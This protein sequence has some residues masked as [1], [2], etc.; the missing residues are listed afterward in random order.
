MI[1]HYFRQIMLELG[2]DLNDDSLK[3]TPKRVA[4]MYKEELFSG[5]S[6]P[7]PTLTTF[8]NK[9]HYSQMLIEQGISVNSVCE[10]HFLPIVGKAAVAYIP[11]K[12]I[13]GLSKLNRIVHHYCR[14]PQ[15]QERLTEQIKNQ[16][17]ETL[18]TENVAVLLDAAHFCVKMRGVKDHNCITR[19]T[20]L[21]G[22]F[23]EQQSTR[24]EFLQAVGKTKELF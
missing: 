5:L 17:I 13:I 12:K 21:G 2:L 10:H 8:D 1:E 22:V 23:F 16:L 24:N 6:D 9:Y 18:E 7:L 11:D 14:R 3:D 20:S 15:V 19:T 4:K